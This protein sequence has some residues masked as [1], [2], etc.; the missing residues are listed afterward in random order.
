MTMAQ[1]NE[2]QTVLAAE[3]ALGTLDS[4]E[5]AR[6]ESL[7]QIEPRYRVAVR[8]WERQLGALNHLVGL[9]EPA[10]EVWQRILARTRPEPVAAHP[11]S[12][13]AAEQLT[14]RDADGVA[15]KLIAGVAAA[16]MS[17]SSQRTPVL[18]PSVPRQRETPLR[19]PM[20]VAVLLALSA[21][22]AGLAY[23]QIYAPEYL[24]PYLRA[25]PLSVT[26]ATPVAAIKA[27]DA[28]AAPLQGN[29]LY[30]LM[31]STLPD[32]AFALQFDAGKRTLTIRRFIQPP[33]SDRVHKLWM[34]LSDPTTAEE[35]G[36]LPVDQPSATFDL[37]SHS[38]SQLSNATY[39]I[40]SEPAT[41]P[42]D[43]TAAAP[44]AL[45]WGKLVDMATDAEATKAFP[46]LTKPDD[47][48]VADAG[49]A[50]EPKDNNDPGKQ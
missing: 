1:N 4:A 37:S 27:S 39:F 13:G 38:V 35:V 20:A 19:W 47:E 44:E 18:Q 32:T 3:Y 9:V 34:I 33:E 40:S 43:E 41:S 36:F 50:D 29:L 12:G 14:E 46:T 17:A 15:E 5:R 21:A 45:F 26:E 7:M 16:A 48:P 2:H 10:P 42:S 30:A 22:L 8:R 24:P 6:V 31:Q 49:P 11:P 23:T 25:K 28:S